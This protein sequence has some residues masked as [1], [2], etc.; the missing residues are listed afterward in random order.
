M[1]KTI[2]KLKQLWVF[3][4]KHLIVVLVLGVVSKQRARETSELL[5]CVLT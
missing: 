4:H 2:H 3:L 5:H 1:A